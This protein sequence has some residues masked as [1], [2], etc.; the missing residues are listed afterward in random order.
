MSQARILY[1]I[2]FVLNISARI[3][4]RH[5]WKIINSFIT[6]FLLLYND[7]KVKA[8]YLEYIKIH[9]TSCENIISFSMFGS[10]TKMKC[11]VK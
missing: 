3:L 6:F 9:V 10:L 5:L 4:W 7:N 1:V 11:K 8:V 2:T